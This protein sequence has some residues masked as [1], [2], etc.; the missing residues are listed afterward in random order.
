MLQEV[1]LEAAVAGGIVTAEQAAGL[2]ALAEQRARNE[3]VALGH[4]ERFLFMRSFNDFFFA[5]GVALLGGGLVFFTFLVPLHSL[6]AALAI[7]ALAELLVARMRLV[8]PGILLACLFAVLVILAS[9]IDFLFAGAAQRPS[10]FAALRE[11]YITPRSEGPHAGGPLMLLQLIGLIAMAY[12]GA[13]AAGAALFY[14]R[15]RLPFALLL[16]AGGLVC[17]AIAAIYHVWPNRAHHYQP[18]GMLVCGLAT[19]VAAM[20][21]DVSDRERV[22]RRAD[23][24]FWLHLL[25]APLI[26]HSLIDLVWPVASGGISRVALNLTNEAA[27]AI[28]LIVATLSVVAIVT[29]RRALLVSA[30]IYLGIVI[31]YAITGTIGQR[32]VDNTVIFFATLFVLGAL[33]VA[34]GVGWQPLRRVFLRLLP[35]RMA[36]L[37][38]PP[39][40]ARRAA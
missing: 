2:R 9:P 5:I 32:G 10:D 3:A 31:G 12:A 35:S 8:L 16:I 17:M 13:G 7:W 20:A 24:A 40:Q 19:F 1:D 34:L 23:C 25:A 36:N 22:T 15:F 29:D 14:L 28:V 21:F 18:I 39:V 11:W 6:I 38:P 37:L 26:V 30:L 33:V 27:A 4:E